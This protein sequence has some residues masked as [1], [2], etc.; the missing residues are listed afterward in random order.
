M[1]PARDL[2]GKRYLAH[3]DSALFRNKSLLP[4]Q[5]A[6]KPEASVLQRTG[7]RLSLSQ[8]TNAGSF[9]ADGEMGRCSC[10]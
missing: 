9:F 3:A 5:K 4:F 8:R 7:T 2:S 1:N 10:S 6:G